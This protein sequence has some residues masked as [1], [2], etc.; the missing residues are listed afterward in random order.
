MSLWLDRLRTALATMHYREAWTLPLPL[1]RS[2]NSFLQIMRPVHSPV[3]IVVHP[4]APP[5]GG[6]AFRRYLHGLHRMARGEHV[7]LVAH[8]SV[9]DECGYSCTRCSNLPT[10]CPPPGIDRIK[11]LIGQLKAAGT[12]C[13]AFT[14]G[15]PALRDNLADLIAACGDEISTTLFTS[16][17][18]CTTARVRCLKE[19]G[20]K[21]GFVSLDHHRAHVHDSVRGVEGAHQRAVDAIRAFRTAGLYTAAQAVVGPELLRDNELGNYIAFCA[22]IGAHETMLLEPVPVRGPCSSFSAEDRN[23]L[24]SLHLMSARTSAMPKVNTMSLL[25]SSRCLGCQAGFSFLYIRSNGDVSPCDFAPVALGNAY[26]EGMPAVLKRLAHAF[27]RPTVGCL[28]MDMNLAGLSPRP[29]PLTLE[30]AA[31][32]LSSRSTE[33]LPDGMTWLPPARTNNMLG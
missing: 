25:E 29:R 27:P 32:F 4:Y 2:M 6:Q 28:A 31:D 33:R 14:G 24:E 8:I 5:I 17:Q 13:V 1:T 16:G 10:P 11:N 12:V 30:D 21:L 7:P 9:T 3:G 20:L 23:R 15:E 22:Q 26:L 18:N 19:A